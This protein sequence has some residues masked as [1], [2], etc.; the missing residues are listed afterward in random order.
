MLDFID[1]IDLTTEKDEGRNRKTSLS[2]ND[3]KP[4]E[5][6]VVGALS[7]NIDITFDKTNAQKMIDF[8]QKIVN[9]K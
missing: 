5:L 3:R 7:H 6:S 9:K 1:V 8:C 2:I 4:F